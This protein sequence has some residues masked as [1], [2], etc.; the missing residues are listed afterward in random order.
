MLPQNGNKG[1]N[2]FY[3]LITIGIC[4][5]QPLRLQHQF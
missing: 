3:I 2:T 1:I 4:P 5:K